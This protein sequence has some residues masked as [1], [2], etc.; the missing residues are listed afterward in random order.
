MQNLSAL[1]DSASA[2]IFLFLRYSRSKTEFQTC[3]GSD[4]KKI[5]RNVVEQTGVRYVNVFV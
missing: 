1:K 3:C 4:C 2:R 5:I